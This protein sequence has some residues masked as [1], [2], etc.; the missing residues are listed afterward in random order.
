MKR[1]DSEEQME[2]VFDAGEESI[3]DYAD[4]STARVVRPQAEQRAMSLT[5]PAWLMGA[6]D[7]EA[8]RCGVSRAAVVKMWLVERA[9]E[10]RERAAARA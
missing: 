2:R 8:E 1:F 5:L 3:L 9:D 4:M 6:L 10:E 7:D